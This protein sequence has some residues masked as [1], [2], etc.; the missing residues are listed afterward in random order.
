MTDSPAKKV[1]DKADCDKPSKARGL[2]QHH[3]NYAYNHDELP[4]TFDY[5]DFWQFVKREL[6]LA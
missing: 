4:D 5:E 3:Y 1:C 6:N 2:C